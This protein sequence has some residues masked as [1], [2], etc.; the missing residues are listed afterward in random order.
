MSTT[1]KSVIERLSLEGVCNG[2]I[3]DILNE[4][5]CERGLDGLMVF[6]GAHGF[7]FRS[8]SKPVMLYV[9]ITKKHTKTK[10]TFFLATGCPDD[11]MM[12]TI[13]KQKITKLLFRFMD[14]V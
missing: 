8:R 10:W 7:I 4:I 13:D 3:V 12:Q 14:L 5:S 11:E 6:L 2:T 9:N 1:K